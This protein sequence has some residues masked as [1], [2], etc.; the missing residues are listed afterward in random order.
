MMANDLGLEFGDKKNRNANWTDHEVIGFL[1][2]LQED[3]VLKDLS[4]NRNK[5]VFCY[6]AQ[7]LRTEGSEKTW[8]QCRIKLK[9]LKSQYRMLKE[10]IP[11]INEVDL[12]DDDVL[13]Q[14]IADCQGRGISPS[15]IKHVKYVKRFLVKSA[16]NHI[17][18]ATQAPFKETKTS[19]V[20]RGITVVEQPE[21]IS[22]VPSGIYE[23]SL[24]DSSETFTHF[25]DY[26]DE[27]SPVESPEGMVIDSE[28][29]NGPVSKKPKE[30]FEVTQ[31]PSEDYTNL[32]KGDLKD[33]QTY[34]EK[35]NQDMM[36]QFL[37]YQRRYSSSYLKWERE[38]FSNHQ[39]PLS[40]ERWKAETREHKNQMFG[41]FCQTISQCNSALDILLKEKLEAQD[42]VKQLKLKLKELE[43]NSK[44]EKD[45]VAKPGSECSND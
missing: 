40:I 12:E 27:D 11:N 23:P 28:D 37:E 20:L 36:D 22:V 7:K 44:E 3:E 16:D 21:N 14:L 31:A 30:D 33:G 42:E 34:L 18:E 39:E 2:I 25:L 10:R 4:A 9:N 26:D 8:D 19:E 13:K 29:T 43:M 45:D 24:N 41:V 32:L 15:H 5:Q 38:R 17:T 35:F 6:A 1:E